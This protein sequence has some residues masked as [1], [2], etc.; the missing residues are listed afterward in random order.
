MS[1]LNAAREHLRQFAPE[2]ADRWYLSFLE[3]LLQL[4]ANPEIW[5]LAPETSEFPFD[6]RQF[7]FRTKSRRANRAL[8]TIIGDEVRILAI[9]RPGQPLITKDDVEQPRERSSTA[10]R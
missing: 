3:A 10:V 5:P 1:D 7:L 4:E 9:R 8:F 6:L 2:T